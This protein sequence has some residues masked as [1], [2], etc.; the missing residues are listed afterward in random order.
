VFK[1]WEKITIK[2]AFGHTEAEIMRGYVRSTKVEYPQDAGTA[3]VTIECQDDSYRLD[4]THRNKTWGEDTPGSDA[5]WLSEIVLPYGLTLHSNNGQGQSGLEV[6]QNGSDIVFL[7][8]RAEQNGYELIFSEGEVYFGPMQLEAEPQPTIMVYAGSKTNCLNINVNTDSHQADAVGIDVPDE[9]GDGSSETVV[10]PD[11]FVMGP[12]HADSTASGLEDFVWK[13]SGAPGVD[14]AA[15]SEQA[16]HKANEFDI[17]KVN[18]S[19]EL[20]GMLYGHVLKPGLPVG[21]DGLGEVY[22]GIYYVDKVTHQFSYD[23][24]RQVFTL[25]RNAYGD[26]LPAG[27]SLLGAV[28]G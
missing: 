13:M 1:D 27:D 3:K 25:L 18:A 21:V 7:K 14:A 20:D 2:V 8:S 15:L 4:R 26:N 10:A 28:M 12:T 9:T 6:N 11:L 19:G 16:Q 22:N 23:G 17:H 24:Y 5:Q